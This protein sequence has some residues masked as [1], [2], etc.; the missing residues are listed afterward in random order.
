LR[1]HLINIK[2][3]ESPSYKSLQYLFSS[4]IYARFIHLLH[5]QQHEHTF[6]LQIFLQLLWW[7]ASEV[8]DRSHHGGNVSGIF[9][10]HVIEGTRFQWRLKNAHFWCMRV[11]TRYNMI[12][13]LGIALF[14]SIAVKCKTS[15]RMKLNQTPV[16]EIYVHFLFTKLI[17]R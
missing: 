7:H 6:K 3:H 12:R 2:N 17:P 16:S 11:T 13:V 4:W 9:S 8:C 10:R 1:V 5:S 14:G 15:K